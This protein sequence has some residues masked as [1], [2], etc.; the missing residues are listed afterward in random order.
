[1]V[2]HQLLY[3]RYSYRH[4]V[5]VDVLSLL[6]LSQRTFGAPE[7]LYL[8]C[9]AEVYLQ[10]A[11]FLSRLSMLPF[12]LKHSFYAMSFFLSVYMH[13]VINGSDVAT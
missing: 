5:H 4:Y 6:L 11:I 7:T 8:K 10:S 9:H 2:A 3:N 12:P 13:K 1:M